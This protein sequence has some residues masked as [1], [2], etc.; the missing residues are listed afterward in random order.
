MKKE[1]KKTNKQIAK[2]T[3]LPVTKVEHWFRTDKSFAIPSEDIWLKL[4]EVL[5]IKTEVFDASIME[6]EYK[7]GVFEST[8]RVYSDQGKSPTLTA[9]NKEQMIQTKKEYISKQSVEKYVEDVNAEFNDPYNKKTVKGDKSTT[10]RTNSSNGNMWVNEKAI[11]EQ[12]IETATS[13]NGITNIKKGTSGKSWFFEQQTYSKDSKKTRSLKAGSGS[14]NIP[15]VI[16]TKPKQVGVAVDINGHDILKRVYSPEG[17]SPTVNTCQGGNREPKVVTGAAFRGRAFDKDGKRLGT[18]GDS[19]AGKSK[20]MLE[21][22]KDDKSN[23][24]TTVGKDSVVA[25]KIREK[26]KTVRSGGRGSY[27]RHEWDSVDELH[28]RKLT[29]RECE[30]L[31]TVPRDYTAGV[32]NTQRYR[33]LGNG[34]CVAVIEHIY[35]NMEHDDYRR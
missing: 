2:E 10:L 12:M 1:S 30:A 25:S 13:D 33:M 35:Q 24:I 3:D 9:S 5:G 7:D 34:W 32:S 4:K 29:C 8:Q 16:E 18:K 28:W 14:G 22:R 31:Q 11:K 21:L 15:K 27:D 17:K 26:S 23:A 20:Q 6:F 19:I